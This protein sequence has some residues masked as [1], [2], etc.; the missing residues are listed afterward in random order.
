MSY[1]I[2][3]TYRD[4]KTVNIVVPA[5]QVEPFF[6]NLNKRQVHLNKENNVGFWTSVDQLR[7]II[8][9]PIKEIA[10]EPKREDRPSDTQIPCEDGVCEAGKGED[11]PEGE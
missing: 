11:K 4:D 7:H 8:V 1:Q 6:E 3:L 10:D 9:Q 2:T 5:D